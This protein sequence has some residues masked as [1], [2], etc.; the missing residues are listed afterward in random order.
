LT[1]AWAHALPSANNTLAI[2]SRQRLNELEVLISIEKPTKNMHCDHH[3]EE[4]FA[5]T[6]NLASSLL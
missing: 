1:A 3:L 5:R 2:G 4:L 6:S